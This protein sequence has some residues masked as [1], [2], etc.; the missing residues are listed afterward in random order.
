MLSDFVGNGLLLSAH[1]TL[2][3]V[4]LLLHKCLRVFSELL[5]RVNRVIKSCVK[6]R[7]ANAEYCKRRSERLG[8][9]ILIL[10]FDGSDLLHAGHLK[11]LLSVHLVQLL[12]LL[13]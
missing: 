6:N 10:V 11:F 5:L 2:Q 13:L 9:S 12:H 7:S 3:H 4:E 1:F 8:N